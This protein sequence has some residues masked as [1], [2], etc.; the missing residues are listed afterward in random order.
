MH[1]DE[2]KTREQLLG[3][4]AAA[5]RRLAE[6]EAR[7]DR[8]RDAG[9]RLPTSAAEL[10]AIVDALPDLVIRIHRDGT[11]L[12]VKSPSQD[13][14]SLPA[15][16]IVGRNIRE[17]GLPQ[18]VV[19]V[20]LLSM[21]NALLTAD[22]QRFE[23]ALPVPRG[24]RDFEGRAVACSN[25]DVLLIIRDVTESK[26]ALEEK[27]RL[28]AEL[29]QARK[30]ESIGRL[31]GGVAHNLGNF[32][33]PIFGYAELLQ[34]DHTPPERRQ[35]Y[36]R[37]IL[38]ATDGAH[39]LTQ[40]LLAISRE[41]VYEIRRINLCRLVSGFERLLRRSIRESIDVEIRKPGSPII[42]EADASQIENALLN[43]ALNAQD[44]MRGSGRIVIETGE[45]VLDDAG[46][47]LGPG[48]FGSLRVSDTG[49]GI[50]SALHE[51][52]FEP[53]FTTKEPGKG[54]GLGLATVQ[55]IARQLGGDV[56][57]ESTVGAGSTF[58]ILLPASVGAVDKPPPPPRPH[59]AQGGHETVLVVE[60]EE[61][62]RDLVYQIL[63]ANGYQA[64]AA[65]GGEE[66]LALVQ[67]H[68]GPIDLLIT[69]I[70]MP[71]VSGLQLY[72]R[73]L[74][75]RP[76]LKVLYM[77]GYADDVIAGHGF[78]RQGDHFIQKP[79]SLAGLLDK[80][81]AALGA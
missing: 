12:D 26:Q 41:Q 66:C 30:M 29:H 49:S 45:A 14:L 7:D 42:V 36:L 52:I 34:R 68:T 5:R 32:L 62:V 19:A 15:A 21:K 20:H 73:L 16:E 35:K 11:F 70:V 48:R 56:R 54:T 46:S 3:E 60:D 24:R 25:D 78:R 38:K 65:A 6:L 40:Q 67:G 44:A 50:D 55:G 1:Q 10:R 81:R 43:L 17:T 63:R 2:G 59:Q 23:Y 74:G 4:L 76:T 33:V 31:A 28:E 57:L 58:E 61:L 8:K 27:R 69:D 47:V 9:T 37:T 53:F 72:Q 75:L 80:V 22:V 13:V 79:F 39:D 18:Q 51:Q 77:S 64:M 71:Q